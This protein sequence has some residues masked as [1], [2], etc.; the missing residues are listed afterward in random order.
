ML[1]GGAGSLLG[2]SIVVPYAEAGFNWNDIIDTVDKLGLTI[3][4]LTA[5]ATQIDEKGVVTLDT[6]KIEGFDKLDPSLRD[7][8]KIAQ[9]TITDGQEKLRTNEQKNAFALT[10]I[11]RFERAVQAAAIQANPTLR[12]WTLSGIKL[13]FA[14]GL[15]FAGV[16]LQNQGTTVTD[17]LNTTTESITEASERTKALEAVG[18]NIEGNTIT[19]TGEKARLVNLNGERLQSPVAIPGGQVPNFKIMTQQGPGFSDTKVTL[20]FD[21]K[22]VGA[23]ATPSVTTETIQVPEEISKNS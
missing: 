18:I 4:R 17:T 13:S 21:P 15:L 6:S 2:T 8:F 19:M 12:G 22:T 7:A 9:D 16:E 11:S 10:I 3:R 1:G 20:S 14:A 5:Q 23:P